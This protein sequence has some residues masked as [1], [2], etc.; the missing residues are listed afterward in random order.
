MDEKSEIFELDRQGDT[1]VII[2]AANLGDLAFQQIEAGATVILDLLND[3]AFRNAVDYFGTT[4]L[5]FF[6]KLWKRLR[7]RD[8]HMVFCNTSEHH[9]EILKVTKLDTLWTLCGSR[10]EALRAVHV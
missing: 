7:D 4:A 1:L 9:R 6:V 10:E 2:P 8:G 3:G 5:G